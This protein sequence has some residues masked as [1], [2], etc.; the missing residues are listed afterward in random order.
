MSDESLAGEGGPVLHIRQ[1][2]RRVITYTFRVTTPS[3]HA[4]VIADIFLGK[5]T[6]WNDTRL[7]S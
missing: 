6:K 1:Y 2:W 5:I 4:P 7:T 3:A